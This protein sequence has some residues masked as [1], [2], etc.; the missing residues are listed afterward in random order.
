MHTLVQTDVYKRWFAAL[1]DA[2]AQARIN[3][4]LRRVE[5]G[6]LGDCKPVGEGVFELRIDYGPGYR[7]YFVQRGYEVIILLAGGDK[8]S[9]ARDI[10]SA[11]KLARNV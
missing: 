11:L 5:L 8:A 3:V 1:R 9:Q 2:R 6:L 10:K 7:V 4:R